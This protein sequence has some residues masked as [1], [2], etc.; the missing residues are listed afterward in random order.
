[1]AAEAPSR[2]PT[3]DKGAEPGPSRSATWARQAK[4]AVLA[5]A[6]TALLAALVIILFIAFLGVLAYIGLISLAAMLRFFPGAYTP[7][8]DAPLW[9]SLFLTIFAYV[10]GFAG[11]IGLGLVRAYGAGKTRNW[12]ARGFYAPVSGYVHAMR[13]TP[14]FVQLWL[15]YYAV[16][17]IAPTLEFG[18]WNVYF[19]AGLIALTLNTLGY[20]AEVFRGGFQSV[21]QGQIEAAKAMGLTGPQIFFHITLPQSLRLIIL[22][23]TN[24]FISLF[25]ASTITSYISVYE[26]FV[27]AENIGTRF[28]HPI[29]GF[30]MISIF[31]LIINIPL[32][33]GVTYLEGKF[34]IPGLGTQAGRESFGK[35]MLG[36][37]RPSETGLTGSRSARPGDMH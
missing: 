16:L 31:Y 14:F 27:W 3:A 37:R 17:L 2:R 22:P 6:P 5:T 18:G 4:G 26:L 11:A 1:M 32:S 29:E 10:L 30:L 24:E 20:Q 19:W 15:V 21:G 33:R 34:R 35:R 13:G 12:I 7:L 8:W 25:K 9:N 23:L 36:A 28:G